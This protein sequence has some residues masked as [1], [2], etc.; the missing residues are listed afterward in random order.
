MK[1]ITICGESGDVRGEIVTSWKERLPEILDS[2]RKEDIYNLDET[3]CFW[4][5]LPSCG[6]GEKG[7]ECK[8][9]KKSKH[10]FIIA[11]LVNAAGEK[12]TPIVIWKSECPRCF[13]RFDISCLPVKYYHQ[14]KAWM[15][16]NILHSYLTKNAELKSDIF[17]Y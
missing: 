11:F 8:S 12:E 13:K 7:K 6:F 2:Y 16:G 14:K 3:G 9:G 10:R 5:A 17:C 15:T 1:R 4:R